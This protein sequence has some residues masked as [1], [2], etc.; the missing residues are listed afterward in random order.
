[1]YSSFNSFGSW[2]SKVL[3][4]LLFPWI[5]SRSQILKLSVMCL[6][7]LCLT[8]NHRSTLGLVLLRAWWVCNVLVELNIWILRVANLT[9]VWC[10]SF[11][12]STLS[13]IHAMDHALTTGAHLA[14]LHRYIIL[15]LPTQTFMSEWALLVLWGA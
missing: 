13:N 8:V 5:K 12:L 14:S 4:E 15:S 7:I 11:S 10:A 6:L 2:S 1:M 3:L 9:W